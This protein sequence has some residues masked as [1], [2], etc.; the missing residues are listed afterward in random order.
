MN[1][2]LQVM[3]IIEKEYKDGLVSGVL[4]GGGLAT[5]LLSRNQRPR[6]YY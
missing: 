2:K 1:W 6:R 4:I 3:K 5:F